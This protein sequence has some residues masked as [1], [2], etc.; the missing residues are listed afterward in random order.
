M[1]RNQRRKASAERQSAKQSARDAW[2]LAEANARIIG[3]NIGAL[4]NGATFETSGALSCKLSQAVT[5]GHS[6]TGT[7]MGE[8]S[9]GSKAAPETYAQRCKRAEP[10][11]P[12]AVRH[13]HLA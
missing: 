11:K 2:K 7:V 3:R 13:P 10:L 5:A 4:R 1:T 8:R 6:G 9:G 12:L